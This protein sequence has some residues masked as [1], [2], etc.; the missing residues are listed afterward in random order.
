MKVDLHIHTHYS[1]DNFTPLDKT[2]E[3]IQESG[4]DCV[5]VTDHGE[6]AGALE[7][8][9]RAPFKVIVGEEIK[10]K[11][12]EIIGLFLKE[13]IPEKLSARETI[14]RIKDQG[15]LVYIPHPF[16]FMLFERLKDSLVKQFVREGLVDIVEVYNAGAVFLVSYK[17]LH[18]LMAGTY[19]AKA[20]SSDAHFPIQFVGT[21]TEIEDFTD[22]QDFIKKLRKGKLHMKP[23]YIF[24]AFRNII[25]MCRSKFLRY[26]NDLYF[27][28]KKTSKKQI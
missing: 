23:G 25:N 19:V 26:D 20:A 27:P 21:C 16:C 22:A 12:G 5:A 18:E 28:D 10:S 4:L 3:A 9:K 1:Y 14:R 13:R 2:I 24:C 11:E 7:M 8:K 6:I 17:Q 15:G